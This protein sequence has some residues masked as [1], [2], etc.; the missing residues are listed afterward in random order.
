[1]VMAAADVKPL[2][3]GMGMKSTR[4]PV[5]KEEEISP[6][7]RID[8]F[9]GFLSGSTMLVMLNVG[10]VSG[11][12]LKIFTSQC[13]EHNKLLAHMRGVPEV[14]V[15][16]PCTCIGKLNTTEGTS[17]KVD[18]GTRN[19]K[20]CVYISTIISELVNTLTHTYQIRNAAD[21]TQGN[22]SINRAA[23]LSI[24]TYI[25]ASTPDH[26]QLFNISRKKAGSGLG[27]T[28]TSTSTH[29]HSPRLSSPTAN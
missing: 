13:C 16:A 20:S 9:I 1:M 27:T 10:D 19:R 29:M 17:Q 7:P 6:N 18:V 15:S 5:R 12:S 26:P 11:K 2:M 3:T 8:I 28:L 23:M 21:T 14:A 25:H 24:D 4:K 22:S